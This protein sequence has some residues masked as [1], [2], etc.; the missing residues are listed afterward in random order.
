M[1]KS[2]VQI[3]ISRSSPQEKFGEGRIG[4]EISEDGREEDSRS[5]RQANK[6]QTY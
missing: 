1:P 6:K 4:A 3:S 5:T 2:I